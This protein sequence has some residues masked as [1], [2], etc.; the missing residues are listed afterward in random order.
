METKT[1]I[2][3]AP[4]IRRRGLQIETDQQQLAVT[5]KTYRLRQGLSQRELGEKWGCSRYTIM[6]IEAGK[7]ITWEM[8][9]RV[10]VKLSAELEN[11]S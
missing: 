3:E 5:L 11:E 2:I 4:T 10:F 1:T 8:M 7:K 6:R 9:Y